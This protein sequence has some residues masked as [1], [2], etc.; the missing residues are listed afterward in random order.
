MDPN[1]QHADETEKYSLEK[2][3]TFSEQ[4]QIHTEGQDPVLCFPC[5]Y[6]TVVSFNEYYIINQDGNETRNKLSIQVYCHI[7]ACTG[8]TQTLLAVRNPLTTYLFLYCHFSAP[9]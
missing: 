3:G 7:K 9:N 6:P 1:K 5:I 2:S 4:L 8:Y